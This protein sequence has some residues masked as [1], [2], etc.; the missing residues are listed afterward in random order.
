MVEQY[1]QN[2]YSFLA[3]ECQFPPIYFLSEALTLVLW[4][5]FISNTDIQNYFHE[6]QY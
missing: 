2:F 1:A 3:Q 4:L 5:G 6:I